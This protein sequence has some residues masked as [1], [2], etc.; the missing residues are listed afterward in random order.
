VSVDPGY[1]FAPEGVEIIA[2]AFEKSWR[3]IAADSQF[4]HFHKTELQGRLSHCLLK[5]ASAGESDPL[6]LANAAIRQLRAERTGSI[7]LARRA[8]PHEGHSPA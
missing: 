4:A 6:R 3:F 1:A 2:D 8:R 7:S 5:L